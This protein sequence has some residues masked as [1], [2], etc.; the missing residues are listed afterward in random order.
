MSLSFR[1]PRRKRSGRA[2]PPSVCLATALL[3]A[4]TPLA[5]RGQSLHQLY[6]RSWTV[7]EGAPSSITSIAQ[8]AD[9]FLWLG[10]DNGLV[11]FDGESFEPYHLPSGEDLLSS[12]ISV[13]TATPE[14][15]LWIGYQSGGP[16]FLE[17]GH[18]RNFSEAE[19][20]SSTHNFE[21]ARRE[22][23]GMM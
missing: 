19:G 8:T 9:G 2:L 18:I 12:Y 4:S 6:H 3:L 11:R 13:V 17:N 21:M 7:R 22:I 1:Q 16:R 14:G 23:A 20:L 10:T 15:G 5:T